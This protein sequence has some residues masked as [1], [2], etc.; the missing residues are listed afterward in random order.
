[1]SQICDNG[2]IRDMTTE[3]QAEYDALVAASITQY[4]E[5]PEN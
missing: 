1:M 2:I 4:E 3:E 5:I